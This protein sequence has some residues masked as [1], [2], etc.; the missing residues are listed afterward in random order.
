MSKRMTM[1][2]AHEN[3]HHPQP[4]NKWKNAQTLKPMENSRAKCTKKTKPQT[5]IKHIKHTKPMRRNK[6]RQKNNKDTH[7]PHETIKTQPNKYNGG[8]F[9]IT[10]STYI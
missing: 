5:I 10:N 6:R 3:T 2:N 8:R 4:H 7:T 1:N 9:E